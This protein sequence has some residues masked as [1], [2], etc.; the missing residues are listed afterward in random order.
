M[1]TGTRATI[2]ASNAP[3]ASALAAVAL[4]A[5]FAL[6]CGGGDDAQEGP[7][8]VKKGELKFKAGTVQ[9]E[10]VDEADAR[11]LGDYL[12]E[13]KYFDDNPKSV[14][15]KKS[16]DT[17][18]VR[19]VVNDDAPR[20]P[21]YTGMIPLFGMQI[22]N[23][24]FGGEK[25]SIDLCDTSFK[26]V[27]TI[28][29]TEGKLKEFNGGEVY[30][31]SAV[32]EADVDL[33]G[34]YLVDENIY[35][36]TAKLMRLDRSGDTWLVQLI[37]PPGVTLGPDSLSTYRMIGLGFSSGAFG[38]APVKILLCNDSL[39]VQEQVECPNGRRLE[40][41]KGELYHTPEITEELA[42][43]LGEYLVKD[44]FFDGTP[45]SVRVL[46]SDGVFVVQII[47]NA[48]AQADKKYLKAVGKFRKQLSR[49]VFDK[50]PVA[51]HLCD[52]TFT[53]GTV[54]EG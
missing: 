5:A 46:E 30:Y 41:N 2:G 25:V 54:V 17:W 36:G 3:L 14:E 6:A 31:T 12:V 32:Q 42:T 52:P 38:G 8:E 7:G 34:K 48:D 35:D 21:A 39:V 40:F 50:K 47:V 1:T 44:R 45:K 53:T 27:L 33:F 19:L 16:G 28:E 22:A 43:E 26:T 18:N 23:R 9:Y 24:V 37:V 51:I 13:D 10:G 29:A 4:L 11:K 20:D 49:K 15:L